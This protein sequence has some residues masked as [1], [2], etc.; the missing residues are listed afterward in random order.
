VIRRRP[1]SDGDCSRACLLR[2]IVA[3]AAA[4]AGAALGLVAAPA[5]AHALAG[6]LPTMSKYAPQVRHTGTGPTGYTVTFHYYDPSATRVQIKGEWYFGNPHQLSKLSG[7]S[8]TDVVQTPGVLPSDWKPG[9]IPMP[10]P[11]STAANWPVSDMTKRGREWTFT[12]PLPSGIFSYGFYVDCAS[13]TGAGCTE[14]SDPANPPWNVTGGQAAGSV[15]PVSQVYV[16][17]DPRFQTQDLSWQAPNPRHGQ[18]MDV[19]YTTPASQSP[20]GQNYLSV[21]TPPGYDPKRTQPYPTLYML[22]PD[23]EVAW[24]TQGDLFN[25]LDNLIDDG[26]IQPMV[27]VSVNLN[28]IP[29]SID[30]SVF[31]ANLASYVIPYIQAHYNV[32]D[33]ASQR[34]VGGLGNAA[35]VVNSLLFD[36]TAEFG[37]Y[38]AFG[39]GPSGPFTLPTASALSTS[40]IAALKGVSVS[41][42][43]GYQDPHHWYHASE[44][45]LL[46]SIGVPVFPD[47]VNSGHDWYSWRINAKDFLTRVAFFPSP[48]G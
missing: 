45:A 25:I 7:S 11:N 4:L 28:G 13:A 42:G 6:H 17:A 35:A 3:I 2:R 10:Y 46:T 19:T 40:Q 22:A 20:V 29:T 18:L 47:F 41:I 14:V 9:D 21:Y 36:H 12:T 31:D 44:V 23:D 43:G 37:Y 16:P 39:I 1:S 38:G 33:S 27:L 32:S 8:E 34:A 48:A 30:S 26:E 24:S 5:A 15:E